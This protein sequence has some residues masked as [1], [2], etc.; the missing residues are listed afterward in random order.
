MLFLSSS[1]FFCTYDFLT[2]ISLIIESTSFITV[3]SVQQGQSAVASSAASAMH[4]YLP[5]LSPQSLH[6]A[7]PNF[8]LW[9]VWG[10]TESETKTL[11]R[12]EKST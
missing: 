7:C 11:L 8:L 1:L 6:I 3:C 9:A 2:K 4:T 5:Q 10:W 12:T